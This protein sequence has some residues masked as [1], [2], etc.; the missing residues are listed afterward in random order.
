MKNLISLQKYLSILL[1]T[2]ILII[3]NNLLRYR[4]IPNA[5]AT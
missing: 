4:V 3:Y 5:N 1:Y 2:K